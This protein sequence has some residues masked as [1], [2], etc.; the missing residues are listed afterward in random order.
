[1]KNDFKAKD[2]YIKTLIFII[3]SL[4]L[5]FYNYSSEHIILEIKYGEVNTNFTSQL[6]FDNGDGYSEEYSIK[7]LVTEKENKCRF[8]INKEFFGINQIRFDPTDKNNDVIINEVNIY[9]WGIKVKS[10]KGQELLERFD[11]FI[12]I[13]SQEVMDYGIKLEPSNS[14]SQIYLSKLFMKDF[15]DL[16]EYGVYEVKLLLFSCLFILYI[17]SIYLN[18]NRLKKMENYISNQTIIKNHKSIIIISSIVIPVLILYWK[19]ITYEK[20]HIFSDIGSDSYN[21]TF[22]T[23]LYNSKYI[24]NFLSIPMWSFAVGLGQNIFSLVLDPFNFILALFG[25]SNIPYL[26]GVFQCIKVILAGNLFYFYLKLIGR[27]KYVSII[28]AIAY[29]FCGHIIGRGSWI[30]YPNEVVCVAFLLL[31]FELFYQKKNKKLIPISLAFIFITL[32]GYY[33]FLYSGIFLGYALFRYF[34][35]EKFEI[36]KFIKY[37]LYIFKLYIIGTLISCIYI[38]PSIIYNFAGSRMSNITFSLS[39]LLRSIFSINNSDILITSYA[40]MLSPGMMGTQNYTG[41]MNLL[42]DPLYYCG[43]LTL[44]IMPQVFIGISK[45]K[46]IGYLFALFIVV[47][48]IVSPGVRYLAGGMASDQFKISSFWIIPVLLYLSSYAFDNMIKNKTLNI[49]LLAITVIIIISPLFIINYYY[50]E[51]LLFSEQ[52]KVVI[53]ILMYLLSI[54]IIPKYINLS[55]LSILILVIIEVVTLSYAVV[56]DRGTISKEYVINKGYYDN[57]SDIVKK[58]KQDDEDK[59]YRIT[60][61]YNSVFLCDSLAQDYY[62]TKSY[63]GG[64][65]HTK[66]IIDFINDFNLPLLN[67]SDHYINGFQGDS[68]INAMIGVKYILS[69]SNEISEYGYE[70]IDSNDDVNIFENKYNLPLAYTYDKYISYDEFIKMSEEVKRDILQKA[71]IVKDNSSFINEFDINNYTNNKDILRKNNIINS[72]DIYNNNDEISINDNNKKLISVSFEINRNKIDNEENIQYYL[73]KIYWK[74]DNTNFNEEDS[75]EFAVNNYTNKYVFDIN[76]ENIK[77]IKICLDNTD[78]IQIRNVSIS[79]PDLDSYYLDY[80]NNIRILKENPFN[81]TL[82]SEN[83][84][85]GNIN[86]KGNK[87]LFFSIPYDKGWSLKIDGKPAELKNVNIGFMGTE[88]SDGYHEIELSYMPLGLKVG[89][90]LTI[91]G[92][93]LYIVTIVIER[94]RKAKK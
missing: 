72:V 90:L 41:Y 65:S 28:T 9:N 20:I 89:I 87:M 76:V 31:A 16:L 8:I 68:T 93:I 21:Q 25:E 14:D 5:F 38:I 75:I 91:I 7:S 10:I 83:N 54:M 33:F 85:K 17:I 58:I 88:I 82:F 74:K 18:P 12:N 67:G 3:L 27:S 36:N 45:N 6:F 81:I 57:T 39:N 29:A 61:N 80:I 73:G 59:F 71:C 50:P 23:I 19:Y 32:K 53:I 64:S 56:N 70:K 55:K 42:E 62:G 79:S 92:L 46:K 24:N 78:G 30:S 11:K 43:L 47:A 13:S 63:Q 69:K 37:I 35:E 26:I 66:E 15:H 84:I 52:I 22:P 94:K 2:S 60:K 1:M 86:V 49:K 34:T 51:K 48:Y 44:I 40:K 77:K 4:L